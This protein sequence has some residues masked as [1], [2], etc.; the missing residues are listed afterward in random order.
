MPSEIDTSGPA[1][2][3]L[4]AAR[5]YAD[6]GFA[7]QIDLCGATDEQLHHLNIA[8]L[9]TATLR[10]LAKERDE[11]RAERDKHDTPAWIANE[12]LN[13]RVDQLAAERDAARAEAAR[14]REALVDVLQQAASPMGGWLNGERGEAIQRITNITSAALAQKEPRH[15]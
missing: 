5:D 11:L 15:D 2:E 14:L 3:R 1:V 9:T 12:R 7:A 10:A 13:A 8:R 6:A 4:L